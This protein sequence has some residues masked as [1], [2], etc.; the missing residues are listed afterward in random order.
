MRIGVVNCN[1]SWS[2]TLIFVLSFSIIISGRLTNTRCH[3]LLST[4]PIMS[5]GVRYCCVKEFFAPERADA[6]SARTKLPYAV[7]FSGPRGATWAFT[8][9][10]IRGARCGLL[11]FLVALA[12]GKKSSLRDRYWANTQPV[13][14]INQAYQTPSH[15]LPQNTSSEL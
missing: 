1:I 2:Q 15:Y 10:C 12:E 4:N 14:I 5:S 3:M 9:R 11:V 8:G 7:L 6:G 13:S